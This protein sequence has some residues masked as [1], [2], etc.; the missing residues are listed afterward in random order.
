MK[1][2]RFGTYVRTYRT[3][4]S[5]TYVEF[6]SSAILIVHQKLKYRKSHSLTRLG[7]DLV[8]IAYFSGLLFL[9]ISINIYRMNKNET[10]LES[11][12]HVKECLMNI[13]YVEHSLLK[14]RLRRVKYSEILNFWGEIVQNTT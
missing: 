6:E 3:L 2:R 7:W 4:V 14:D 12:G 9:C 10:V 13:V 11:S 1:P 8:K 5:S